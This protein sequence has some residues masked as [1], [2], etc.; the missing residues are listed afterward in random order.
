MRRGEGKCM[1]ELQ[2]MGVEWLRENDCGLE[3]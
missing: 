3:K 2:A 1:E